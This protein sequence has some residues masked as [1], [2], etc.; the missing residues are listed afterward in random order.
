M[1][2]DV[3]FAMSPPPGAEASNFDVFMSFF[4]LI[5]LVVIFYF[6][7]FRPQQKKQKETRDMIASLK[8]GD[9]VITVGGMYG[10]IV[11]IKD[12]VLTLNVGDNVKVRVNRFYVAGQKDVIEKDAAAHPPAN[13]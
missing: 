2:N 1:F 6:F 10:T 9:N 3:A 11:K 5:L 8:E 12:D 7:L 13:A 4:P